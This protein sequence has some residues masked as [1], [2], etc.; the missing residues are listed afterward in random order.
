MANFPGSMN[1]LPSC[2]PIWVFNIPRHGIPAIETDSI[3]REFKLLVNKHQA[4]YALLEEALLGLE[5]ID[6][7]K[8]IHVVHESRGPFLLSYHKN[9]LQSIK[10]L[11]EEKR[12]EVLEII[13]IVDRMMKLRTFL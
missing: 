7:N 13:E 1:Y 10:A 3:G 12:P 9:K 2:D 5:W 11:K 6:W 4:A 8:T